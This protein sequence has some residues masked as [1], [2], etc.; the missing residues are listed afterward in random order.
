ML[1][2]MLEQLRQTPERNRRPASSGRFASHF[3]PQPFQTP[4]SVRHFEVEDFRYARTAIVTASF[5]FGLR[6]TW[7]VHVHLAVKT[8]RGV[9]MLTS[10]LGF[11]RAAVK[12]THAGMALGDERSH[13]ARSGECHRLPVV[14]SGAF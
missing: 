5:C 6:E 7:D 2:L 13:P 1:G 10:F 11:T 8:G 3:A 9:K 14:S 4:A 12:P